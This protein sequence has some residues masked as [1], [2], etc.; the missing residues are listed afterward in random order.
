MAALFDI[1]VL[2]AHEAAADAVAALEIGRD[3]RPGRCRLAAT[4]T[5]GPNGALTCRWTQ[6]APK[7]APPPD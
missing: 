2:R 6:D 3:P 4:W 7:I 1:A 5:V